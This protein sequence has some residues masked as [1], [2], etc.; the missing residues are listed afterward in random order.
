MHCFLALFTICM[1]MAQLSLQCVCAMLVEAL[2][3]AMV[4]LEGVSKQHFKITLICGEAV[5]GEGYV[6]IGSLQYT[7]VDAIVLYA[8]V[9]IAYN[10]VTIG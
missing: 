4:N 8:V 1:R 10:Q 9:S 3:E 7:V 5:T 6:S 2:W